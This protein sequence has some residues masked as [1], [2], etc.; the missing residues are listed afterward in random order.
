MKVRLNLSTKPLQTHRKFLAGAGILGVVA[1]LFFIGLGLHVYAVRRGDEVFRERV[2]TVRSEM[3]SLE[4]QRA[5]LEQFFSRPENAKLHDRS[6]FLNTLIDEQ[7]LNWTQMFMD[8]EKILP[9]GVRVVSIQPKHDKGVVEVKLIVGAT[10]DEAKLKFLH[11]LEQSGSFTH[12]QV[13]NQKQIAPTAG[14][15]DKIDVELNVVYSKT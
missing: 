5:D 8:L 11:A 10:S 1:G 4:R 12:L 15:N 2:V 7:S 9:A 14:S 6:A 13:V 3:V